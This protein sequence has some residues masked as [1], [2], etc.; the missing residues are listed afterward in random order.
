MKSFHSGMEVSKDDDRSPYKLLPSRFC[1]EKRGE[2]GST[3]VVGTHLS[4]SFFLDIVE[5]LRKWGRSVKLR[6]RFF[7]I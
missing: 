3:I 1:D 7:D 6:G 4:P 2:V 5:S